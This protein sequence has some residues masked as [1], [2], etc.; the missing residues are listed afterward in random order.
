MSERKE[1]IK[2]G[3]NSEILDEYIELNGQLYHKTCCCGCGELVGIGAAVI[4]GTTFIFKDEYHLID[5]ID[6]NTEFVVEVGSW[7]IN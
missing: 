4:V 3:V 1:A 6:Q 2:Y 7:E 5:W